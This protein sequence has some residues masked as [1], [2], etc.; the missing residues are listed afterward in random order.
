[1]VSIYLKQ[2]F[3]LCKRLCICYFI[4]FICRLLFFVANI[5]SFPDTG[6]GDFLENSFYGLRFDS[7]SIVVSNSLFIIL[8]LLPINAFQKKGYQAVLR[9]IFIITNSVFVAANVIDI[10]Y[11]RFIHKRSSADLFEQMGGQSDLL[12]LAP[13]FLLDFWWAVLCLIVLIWA[14]VFIYKRVNSDLAGKYD[15]K[16]P[17]AWI[18]IVLLFLL[19]AGL[20]VLAV[21]GGLQRVPIDI[22]NA[23]SVAKP[24][25]VPI[26]LNTPFTL[27]KSVAQQAVEEFNFYS[28][29]QVKNLYNPYQQ[30]TGSGLQKQN[31]V[32][33][34]LESFSKE[35]TKLG[36]NK[37]ITP[38]LDSLMDR[39]LV[40]SNAFSNGSRS[41]EGIPAILSSLPTLMEN[42]FI[43]SIYA[44]NL[45]TS[46]A[47]ILKQEGYQTAFFHGGING[48]MNFDDWAPS[49]GYDLYYGKKEYKND[50]DFD[51]FWGIWDEP[52]LQYSV[53]KMTEMK[54]PFHSAVF[55]LSSHHPYFVPKRYEQ[56]L[57]KGPLENSQSIRYADLSLR[58]FFASAQKEAWYS[59]TLFIIAADHAS[60]S[61]HPFYSNL[62]GNLSIPVLF[63]K[64]D[65]SLTGVYPK[66]FSQ[67]DVL[68]SALDVLG[69]NKPFFSFGKSFK[70]LQAGTA[71]Y[72]PGGTH[73]S[74]SDS[75]VYFFNKNI[76]NSAFNYKRDSLM[77]TNL[78]G[79]NLVAD[80]NAI[81]CFKAFIQTYNYT[82]INNKGRVK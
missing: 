54:Q 55:T 74:Y 28:E 16:N 27:I 34:I 15:G 22:V 33:L 20:S 47:S 8:S 44:N 53:K 10:A 64:P 25:E 40:F 19:S 30:L 26:V 60:I 3:I 46:F 59:N 51:N 36:G 75:M 9:W 57:A 42:P 80:S 81:A 72:Y 45:Q 37:G 82:L 67:V 71:F 31:V 68:P 70:S 65:N 41:I 17:A 21:R 52:F 5:A 39:S 63:F 18:V 61:K 32:V 11:F 73:I 50:E 48:T 35:Y 23:G 14:M 62:V 77:T 12:K 1:M 7:F 56:Q 24:E 58:K 69:Y 13:Q 66:I 6:F 38:F 79:Q 29:A 4:Y 76:P 43:N 2:L 78:L 49:A